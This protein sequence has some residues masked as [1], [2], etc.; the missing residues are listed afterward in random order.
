M[1]FSRREW[2]ASVLAGSLAMASPPA[3]GRSTTTRS[4]AQADEHTKE[5]LA[6]VDKGL[7]WLDR[8]KIARGGYR[9][10]IGQAEDIGCT[11]M[12]GLAMLADGSTPTKGPNKRKLQAIVSYLVKKIEVMPA[13]NITAKTNTQLQSK[14]G[15][16]AHS[17]FAL[18]FLTQI[19][20]ES[21]LRELTL[22][23]SRKLAQAVT[24][25]QLPNGGWGRE[26]WAPTL[27]TVMGW[28]SLRSAHFAGLDVAGSPE[29]TA[30]HLIKTMESQAARQ[31][32]MHQL[33]KNAAGI[34]V[35]YAMQKDDKEIVKTSFR[36]VLAL[37]NKGNTAFNQAGGEEYLA[38]HL[39]TETMLQKGGEDWNTWFPKVRDKICDV[40]NKDG[41]W[42]GHHCITSRTFCTAAA[43]M[44]LSAPNRYLPISQ[45]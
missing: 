1:P 10:D 19:V 24:S 33:Y 23:S 5:S 25:A 18:L 21:H 22:N 44:V 31:N 37:V 12:V 11:A 2:G 8:T 29:K 15:R 32:W 28:T 41:S 36:D 40:Q 34:R 9:V 17:F 30:E 6:A 45:Q 35:L 42:T 4:G 7:A 26:S 16:Q 3:W 20:G 39:I 43:C 14:I 27:G 13:S 38:F